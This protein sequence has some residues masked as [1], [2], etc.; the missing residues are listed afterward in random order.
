MSQKQDIEFLIRDDGYVNATLICKAGN[1]PFSKYK[2]TK[3][4]EAY[5]NELSKDTN[6]PISEL[7]KYQNGANHVRS[8]WVHRRVA[9]HIAQW[10]SPKFAVLI[11]NWIEEWIIINNNIGRYEDAIKNIEPCDTINHKEKL[12][13]LRLHQELG[14]EIEVETEIGYID[15][16][17]DTEII[18]IKKG[19]NWK[20][21]IGQI[22]TY[23]TNYPSHT[24]RIH[25]FDIEPDS[26]IE[27]YC[28]SFNIVVTYE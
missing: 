17:T 27:K 15:L 23:A 26:I 6:I 20:H 9:T 18:E 5:L 14:G 1:K 19:S 10:I 12:I 25:L 11:S 16:L 3:S 28:K 2:Q 13:Q 7:I 8:T 4:T 24:K 21:A 22:L